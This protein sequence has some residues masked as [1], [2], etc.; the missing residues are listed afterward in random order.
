MACRGVRGATTVE[1]N[2]REEILTATRQL[3]ALM[4]RQN[5]IK[6]ED[7]ASAI[8]TTT[9]DIDA[10][11]PALAAR[12]LGLLDVPLLC[13]HEMAVP[14]SLTLCVRI[15]LHWNTD[16]AQSEIRHVYIRE[17]QRLRPDIQK[18]PPVDLEELE[19]WI[20]EQM[21]PAG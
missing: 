9:P 13:G 8:F 11:F 15:L 19:A 12:Q 6:P 20:K 1:R 2:E 4:L 7:V 14:G 18:L 17:A 3:L 10:E 16:K 5:Q 21:H